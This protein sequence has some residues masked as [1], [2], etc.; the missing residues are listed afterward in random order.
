M[1]LRPA[2]V[3]HVTVIGTDAGKQGAELSFASHA[4]DI[5]I[6]CKTPITGPVRDSGILGSV[7]RAPDASKLPDWTHVPSLE[8]LAR[9]P[10]MDLAIG[11][12]AT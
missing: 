8:S 2:T 9:K 10:C 6:I 12:L 4:D 7:P 11:D 1:F 5:G 3:S